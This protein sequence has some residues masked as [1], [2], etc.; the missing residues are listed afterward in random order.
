[1]MVPLARVMIASTAIAPAERGLWLMRFAERAA[2]YRPIRGRDVDGGRSAA[3]LQRRP[4][5]ARATAAAEKG[6]R[7]E[8]CC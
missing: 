2:Q 6:G 8:R 4:A 3:A 7:G 1:M 5:S